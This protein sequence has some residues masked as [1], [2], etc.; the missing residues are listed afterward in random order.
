MTSE[1]RLK[2]GNLELGQGLILAPMAGV[3]DLSFRRVAKT[4]GVDLVTSEMVS[5]E[6]LAR[7]NPGTFDLLESHP[8]EKPLSIQLFGAESKVMG[9]AARMVADQGADIIDLN[10]G[11]PVTKVLRQGAGAALLKDLGRVTRMIES[12]RRAVKIPITVK[13]RAGWNGSQINITEMGR[14]AETA[15]ADAITIHPRTA[16]QGYSGDADWT[17]VAKLKQAVS[18]PVIGNGDVTRPEQVEELRQLAGCDGVMIGR[19]AM[20]N[21]WIFQQAKQL[22]AGKKILRPSAQERLEVIERHLTLHEESRQCQ[23]S[24]TYLRSRLM[25]YSKGLPGSA[26]LRACLS[27][28][29]EAETMIKVCEDL[30]NN[31]ATEVIIRE[32]RKE[33][34]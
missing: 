33:T 19:A 13:T 16:K 10:M 24:L 9:E 31:L 1:P 11:C 12:V 3:T 23:P 17:L 28:C 6:G 20:G 26:R 2:I 21:P 22:A 5:A 34:K 15:G 4:F 7:R 25:W 32:E 27:G 14:A 18:I 8:E 30:F 29:R